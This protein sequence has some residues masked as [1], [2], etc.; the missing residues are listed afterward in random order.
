[1]TAFWTSRAWTDSHS[2]FFERNIVAVQGYDDPA[3]AE[4][5]ANTANAVPVTWPTLDEVIRWDVQN[6]YPAV[7]GAAPPAA[8]ERLQSAL[9]AAVTHHANRCGLHVR[10][11]D[12]SGAVDPAGDPVPIDPDV[13]L[14]TIMRAVRWA[15]RSGTPD[16]IAGASEI[17]GLIRTSSM[18]PDI[19]AMIASHLH[20]GLA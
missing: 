20:I 18:D 8:L 1:M 14:A 7:A 17:G 4:Y 12:A 11:V 3:A 2:D 6:S 19:E 13:K 10:P 9:D 15:R 5:N 16:G